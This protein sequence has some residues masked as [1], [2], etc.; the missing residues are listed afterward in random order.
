MS[1][2]LHWIYHLAVALAI[3]LMVGIE[4]GWKRREEQEGQRTAG[5]RTF[6][7]LGMLGGLAGLIG[8]D[9]GLVPVALMFVGVAGLLSVMYALDARR[10][11]DL[12]ATT[13]VAALTTFVLAVMAGLGHLA[14]RFG[15]SRSD[16][17]TA[18]CQESASRL[19]GEAESTRTGRGGE[20]AGHL[21]GSAAVIAQ[22]GVRSVAE[23]EPLCDLVDGCTG[24]RDFV[25]RLL[26]R[27]SDWCAVP[28][29]PLPPFSAGLLRRRQ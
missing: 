27:S 25:R 20:A 14:D 23:S 2:D 5:F 12:G 19:A 13:E 28:A 18:G 22:S 9:G 15:G 26:W 11:D 10:R 24:G 4:R 1:D 3:G 7:L 17:G 29:S 21:G 16:G 6:G 8:I